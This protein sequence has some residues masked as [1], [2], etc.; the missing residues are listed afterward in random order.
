MLPGKPQLN[1]TTAPPRKDDEV[2]R[3]S[4]DVKRQIANAQDEIDNGLFHT[5]DDVLKRVRSWREG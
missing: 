1:E 4:A 2:I 5:H 3:L